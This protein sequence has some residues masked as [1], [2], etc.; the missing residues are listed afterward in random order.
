MSRADPGFVWHEEWVVGRGGEG[1]SPGENS[2]EMGF[3]MPRAKNKL[4]HET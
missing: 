2:W 1:S 3:P 4:M